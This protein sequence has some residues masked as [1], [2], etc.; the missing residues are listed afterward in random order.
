MIISASTDYRQ[1][2]KAKLPPFLF[3]YIDGDLQLF[4]AAYKVYAQ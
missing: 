2:A 1:T 3:D 4:K